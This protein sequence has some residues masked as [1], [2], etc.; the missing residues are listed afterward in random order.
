MRNSYPFAPPAPPVEAGA[1]AHALAAA[2]SAF[3]KP[4]SKKIL[5]PPKEWRYGL[6]LSPEQQTIC[7]GGFMV[8][9]DYKGAD[10]NVRVETP[11]GEDVLLGK[12]F[13]IEEGINDLLSITVN[14]LAKRDIK[15]EEFH[16]RARA[17]RHGTALATS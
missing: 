4:E 7:L 5:R 8:A 11:L 10:R 9:V 14:V 12:S 1:K 3:R 6:V 2:M 15:P 17:R 16:R 13:E